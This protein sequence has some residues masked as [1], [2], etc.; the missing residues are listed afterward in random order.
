MGGKS[1]LIEVLK[2]FV[3]GSKA[4][5]L[6]PVIDSIF[7]LSRAGDAQRKMEERKNFGKIVLSM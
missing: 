5:R 3:G 2:F 7:P 4:R 1:E 6:Q